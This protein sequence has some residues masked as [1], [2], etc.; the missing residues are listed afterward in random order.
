MSPAQ[1]IP[2]RDRRFGWLTVL[3]GVAVLLAWSVSETPWGLVAYGRSLPT[4][5]QLSDVIFVGEGMNASVAVSETAFGDRCFHISGKV[6]ASTVPTDMRLQRMLGH[7]PACSTQSLV[8]CSLWDAERA[9][10]PA[11]S[12]CTPTSRKSSSAR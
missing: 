8:R 12:C 4:S 3:T 10:R 11:H 7:L 9:S 6:E 1:T 5:G 2:T